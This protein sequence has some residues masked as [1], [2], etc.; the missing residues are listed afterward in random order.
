MKKWFVILNSYSGNGYAMK[1][2]KK[3]IEALKQLQNGFIIKQTKHKKHEIDLVNSATKKGYKNFISIG[4]DGTLHYIVNGILKQKNIPINQIKIAVIPTGTGNDWVKQYKIPFDFKKNMQIIN[5]EK[6]FKQDIGKIHFNSKISYFNNAAGIGFD[7]LVVKELNKKLGKISYLIASL[8]S[9][10]KYK[11]N[12]LTIEYNKQVKKEKTLL[13]TIGICKY[14]GGGMQLTSNVNPNDGLL[15]ITWIT[16]IS[17]FK[18]FTNIFKLY[19]GKLDTH[20][21][22][23]SF[24]TDKIHIKNHLPFASIQ[25]DGELLGKGN[26]HIEILPEAVNFV[27]P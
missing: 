26:L 3:I 22:V 11:N 10:F 19:N 18:L 13:L 24:K 21:S 23:K 8:K 9:A 12:T 15:D 14:S 6:I 4:G 2:E 16:D 27:I 5:Q 25:A 17:P 20:P 7:A 1:N